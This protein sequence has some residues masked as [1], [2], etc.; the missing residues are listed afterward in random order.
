MC[1]AACATE[2]SS[3]CSCCSE[4]WDSIAHPR[5]HPHAP[6][7]SWSRG[8][9]FPGD[10][11]YGGRTCLIHVGWRGTRSGRLLPPRR[12]LAHRLGSHGKLP[13]PALLSVAASPR[14]ASACCTRGVFHSR[15][16]RRVCERPGAL[17]TP[18]ARGEGCAAGQP[19]HCTKGPSVDDVLRASCTDVS[20]EGMHKLDR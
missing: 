18:V 4:P 19:R 11:Q 5:P 13:S 16:P 7:S 15:F 17:S 1:A 14:P 10:V 9:L 20:A 12:P 8:A 3:S 6:R 2:S